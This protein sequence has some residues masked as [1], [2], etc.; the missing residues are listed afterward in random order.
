MTNP[1]REYYSSGKIE[2]EQWYL[3]GKLHREDGPAYIKYL[4]SGELWIKEWYLNDQLHRING[5]AII[6]YLYSGEVGY[7]EWHLNGEEIYPEDWL[8]E[9]RYEWPLTKDQ[10]IELILTFG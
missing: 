10:Q 1:K 3:N 2:S 9:H 5:P 6:E 4:Y 7:E 8:K